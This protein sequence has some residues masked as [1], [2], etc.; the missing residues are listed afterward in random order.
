MLPHILV[1][2]EKVTEQTL[3]LFE[4]MGIGLELSYFSLPW[5]LEKD[6]LDAEIARHKTLLKGFSQHQSMHGSFYGLNP[7]ARDPML[8]EVARFRVQ[9][10]LDIAAELEMDKLVFHANYFHSN[11]MGYRRIWT[12]KQVD[13]WSQFIPTLEA[14]GQTMFIENTREENAG[15][16]SEVLTQLDHPRIKTCYDTGHS[17]CFTE[18][19]VHVTEWVKTYGNQLGYIHLHSN[20]RFNDLHIAF[21]KG[22]QDFTG[23]FEAIQSL[24]P[25]P[26]LIVEVKS[27]EDFRESMAELERIGMYKHPSGQAI[28]AD[29]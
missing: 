6:T 1:S 27:R 15:F 18:S 17:N 12:Q 28:P 2:V 25:L 26:W 11:K 23:F 10:S 14:R 13:F 9:Q 7:T 22:K 21:H 5:N 20:D 29:S 24:D 4:E 19:K 16:I 3:E 8:L